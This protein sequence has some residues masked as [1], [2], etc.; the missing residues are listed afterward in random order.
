[1]LAKK[2]IDSSKVGKKTKT[3]K[4]KTPKQL[5]RHIKGIANHR[6]IEILFLVAENSKITVEEI[7][8]N[9]QCNFKTI[10]EHTRRLAQAGLI[11]KNYQGR[12]V[13]HELSPYGKII[14]KFLKT[15]QYS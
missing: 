6:R 9:L 10:S 3:K 5:E 2:F 4:R 7:S 8:K 13:V 12:K 1:M 11:R 15:F 14:Y